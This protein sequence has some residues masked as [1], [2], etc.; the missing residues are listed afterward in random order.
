MNLKDSILH[1]TFCSAITC[2]DVNYDYM[3]ET[4]ATWMNKW[5]ILHLMKKKQRSCWVRQ[6]R[7]SAYFL[8]FK[9]SD[10]FQ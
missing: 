6:G 2:G 3:T 9:I 4:F 8:S 7:T 10:T 5:I 1:Y